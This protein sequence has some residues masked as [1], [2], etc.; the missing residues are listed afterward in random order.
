MLFV[1]EK[2]TPYEAC[3]E[4]YQHVAPRGATGSR[5]FTRVFIFSVSPAPLFRPAAPKACTHHAACHAEPR[6]AKSDKHRR[7]R[8]KS[9]ATHGDGPRGL[10]RQASSAKPPAPSLHRQASSATSR[11]AGANAAAGTAADI[12]GA[13]P[14]QVVRMHR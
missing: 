1:L 4:P 6:R 11:V 10:Q 13:E 12:G 2:D 9:T 8:A 5:A 14:C 3:V 7:H